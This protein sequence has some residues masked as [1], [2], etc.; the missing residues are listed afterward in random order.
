MYRSIIFFFLATG[1]SAQIP[2]F[3]HVRLFEYNLKGELRAWHQPL[4]EGRH[5][6]TIV[7]HGKQLSENEEKELLKWLRQDLTLLEYGLA[8]CYEPHHAYVFYD[9]MNHPLHFMSVCLMCDGIDRSWASKEEPKF[10]EKRLKKAEKQMVD[11]S[12]LIR[13][14]GFEPFTTF[15]EYNNRHMQVTEKM[16]KVTQLESSILMNHLLPTVFMS[17]ESAKELWAGNEL[18]ISEEIA[19]SD[20]LSAAGTLKVE[21]PGGNLVYSISE[22]REQLSHFV[23]DGP[24]LVFLNGMRVGMPIEEVISLSGSQ[25]NMEAGKYVR[26]TGENEDWT[27]EVEFH[28]GHVALIRGTILHY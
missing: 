15:E 8:K 28:A 23:A 22:G 14:T 11:L 12:G 18:R 7:G 25:M 16:N 9:S 20:E 1:A 27:I 2:E 5:D 17:S 13:D 21:G 19:K 4:K 26:F 6:S 10:S 3:H 24:E